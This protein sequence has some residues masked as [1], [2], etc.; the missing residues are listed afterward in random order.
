MY[1]YLVD[2]KISLKKVNYLEG[3]SERNLDLTQTNDDANIN[4]VTHH[5][6]PIE[7]TRTLSKAY[8]FFKD[9]HV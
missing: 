8:I 1:S 5:D 7:Y 6:L 9:G 4:N 3:I 2:R